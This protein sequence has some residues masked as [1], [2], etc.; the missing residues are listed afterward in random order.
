MRTFIVSALALWCGVQSAGASLAP[1][2]TPCPDTE[3]QFAALTLVSLVRQGLLNPRDLFAYREQKPVGV[4][5]AGCPA[6]SAERAQ[7]PGVAGV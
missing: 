6:S 2:A 7:P 1:P 3:R 4:F 5:D